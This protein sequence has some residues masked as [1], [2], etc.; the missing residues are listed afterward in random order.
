MLQHQR[1]RRILD[2][3]KSRKTCT[4]DELREELG[5]SAIT[6][7]RDLRKLADD[8]LIQRVHGGVTLRKSS[9]ASWRF[10][11]RLSAN[12]PAKERIAQEAAKAVR[13]ES[14]IFIDASSTTYFFAR[15]LA[16]RELSKLTL[17]TTSPGVPLLFEACPQIRTISTGGELHQN[18]NTYGGPITMRV[19]EEMNFDAAYVSCAGFSLTHGATT[20]SPVLVEVLR[21]VAARSREVVLLVDSSK[22]TRL[23]MM[24]SLRA[25]E[26]TRIVTDDQVPED[27]L[28]RMRDAGIEVI[29]AGEDSPAGSAN[30]D[31]AIAASTK[32]A[33]N[34]ND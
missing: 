15:Q 33:S 7:Y 14:G 18:L 6:L 27:L 10:P 23:A 2:L 5:I 25:N 16:Q 28:R 30:G 12:T 19:L 21:G 13:E 1:H 20:D 32:Q 8:S 11:D 34:G 31:S 24:T 22:F 26:I 3:V 4:I 17:V 29:V 9:P